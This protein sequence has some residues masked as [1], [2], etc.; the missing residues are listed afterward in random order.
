MKKNYIFTLILALLTSLTYSQIVINEVDA[1]QTGTDTEEFIEL[2][3]TPNTSLDGY[4]VVLFNGSDDQ[5]YAAYDLDGRT[6]DANGLFVLAT[7][8]IASGTDIDMGADNKV[9]NGADAVA[10]YQG[11][12]ADFPVD[13]PISTT[14]LIDVLVYGTSDNDDS[15]LLDGFGVTIQ[16]DEN[17]NGNKDTESIQRKSDGTYEVKP[18]SR[19]VLSVK[20]NTIQGFATYPNPVT[21]NVFTVKS[22]SSDTKEISIFNVLGKK[23]LSKSLSGVQ[24]DVDVSSISA[25]LYILKVKEGTKMATSKLVIK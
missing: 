4:V 13:T 10:V 3:W 11:D 23:V 20:D 21:N 1:D 16:Y 8:A 17:I 9:Q 25:G 2:L 14:N 18:P 22:K 6:T 19:R 12:E 5:S 15:G 24:S 7:T